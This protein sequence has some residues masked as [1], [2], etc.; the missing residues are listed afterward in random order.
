MSG[1]VWCVWLLLFFVAGSCR[2]C[3]SERQLRYAANVCKWL[4]RLTAAPT[5][6]APPSLTVCGAALWLAKHETDATMP[7]CPSGPYAAMLLHML[8][9]T[10]LHTMLHA[11]YM[12]HTP[13]AGATTR[14]KAVDG[15][16]IYLDSDR[17]LWSKFEQPPCAAHMAAYSA[18]LHHTGVSKEAYNMFLD[19]VRLGWCH[20]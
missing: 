14:K 12:S 11:R 8:Q 5:K 4:A 13:G 2:S 3:C 19:M 10:P 6:P 18:L 17:A 1:Q 7:P 16:R 20:V 15:W 9:H